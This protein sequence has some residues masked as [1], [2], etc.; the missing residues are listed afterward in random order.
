MSSLLDVVVTIPI[1]VLF[2]Y[3]QLKQSRFYLQV[4]QK[5]RNL[6]FQKLNTPLVNDSTNLA[7]GE[8]SSDLQAF[9]NYVEQQFM[10]T[11]R[12]W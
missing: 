5:M 3:L 9:E 2:S 11:P 1:I 4:L 7:K 8:P 6:S 12:K 10:I